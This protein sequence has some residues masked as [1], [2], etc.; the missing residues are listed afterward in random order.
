MQI[1]EVATR[2]GLSL[3]T[4]RHYDELK[5]VTPSERS[6]GGFRLYTE[7]DVERL[8]LVKTMRPLD[9]SL[10]QMH[11]L[12]AAIDAAEAGDGP[13]AESARERLAMFRALA[14]SRIEMLRSQIHGLERL[15]RDLRALEG[16]PRRAAGR[17]R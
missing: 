5:I 10:D 1:G 3:R 15:S 8:L 7:A 17:G 2:T 13:A 6:P 14:D 16:S 9:F 4:I 11:E 12:L